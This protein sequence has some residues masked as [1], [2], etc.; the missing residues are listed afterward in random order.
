MNIADHKFSFCF[1][2]VGVPFALQLD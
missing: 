1:A 2:G